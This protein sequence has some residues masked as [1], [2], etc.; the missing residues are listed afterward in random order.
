MNEVDLQEILE[1]FITNELDNK[2]ENLPE[3]DEFIDY[4]TI[5][6]TNKKN[7]G[8]TLNYVSELVARKVYEN[9]IK[10]SFNLN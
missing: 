1:S 4:I 3:P 9:H 2:L 10:H 6:K 7:V 8:D 5:I